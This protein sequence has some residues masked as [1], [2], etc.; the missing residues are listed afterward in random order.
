M[1]NTFQKEVEQLK[2]QQQILTALGHYHGKID[3]VWGPASIAAMTAFEAT[4]LFLPGIPNHGM[5]L[6]NL[7]PW[8]AGVEKDLTVNRYAPVLLTHPLLEVVEVK[9]P[10]VAKKEPTAEPEV[11]K[12]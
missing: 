12:K 7:G 6:G 1:R 8:P 4:P 5:P 11:S 2:R 3:G 10:V 9:P